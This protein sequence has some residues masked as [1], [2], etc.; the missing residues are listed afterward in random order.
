[1]AAR[2]Q[3]VAS[4]HSC[5]CTYEPTAVVTACSKPWQAKDSSN[6][7]MERGAGHEIPPYLKIYGQLIAA[8]RK[9]IVFKDGV[10]WIAFLKDKGKGKILPKYL[11]FL[12]N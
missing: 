4:R 11:A 8:G 12:K 9:F 2:E 1:M 3:T 6:F 7:S 10:N 5:S